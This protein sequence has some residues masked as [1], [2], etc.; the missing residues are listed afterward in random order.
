MQETIHSHAI[1]EAVGVWLG[2]LT[3]ARVTRVHWSSL[4]LRKLRPHAAAVQRPA[5]PGAR[6]RRHR[7]AAFP[8]PHA[9]PPAISLLSNSSQ[10]LHGTSTSQA[11]LPD[12]VLAC[13]SCRCRFIILLGTAFRAFTWH[14]VQHNKAAGVCACPRLPRVL[15]RRG[16]GSAMAVWRSRARHGAASGGPAA[17]LRRRARA[18]R[19]GPVRPERSS[20][21]RGPWRPG[22]GARSARPR[23][24]AGVGEA[25][26]G[27]AEQL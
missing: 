22:S 12:A 15:C 24:S 25:S 2:R 1:A 21:T 17:N 13:C 7:P 20:F 6:A 19:Q 23:A 3:A 14:G 8:C 10:L 26:Q 11:V 18:P 9:S 27:S 16:S 4:A 5:R